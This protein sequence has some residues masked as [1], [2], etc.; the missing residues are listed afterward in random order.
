M[1]AN[2]ILITSGF[3]K[4][5]SSLIK[6]KSPQMYFALGTGL[7]SWDTNGAQTPSVNI[8]SLFNEVYR[9]SI[10]MITDVKYVDPTTHEEVDY[11]TSTI[12]VTVEF[13]NNEFYGNVRE[14]GLFAVN[15]T[16]QLNT[17]TLISYCNHEK[18][19]IPTDAHYTKK[20]Y[21]NT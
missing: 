1:D 14:Y 8:S 20:I 9:Q 2:S 6:G 10:D 19:L 5:V 7:E 17:G 3:S 21:L 11:E 12:C 13:E 16:S 18:M 15:A 4:Y